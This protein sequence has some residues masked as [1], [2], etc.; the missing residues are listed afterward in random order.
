[1][2]VFISTLLVTLPMLAS[3]SGCAVDPR[4]LGPT[5]DGSIGFHLITTDG[6]RLDSVNY[7]LNTQAGDDV[8]DATLDVSSNGSAITLGIGRLPPGDYS[9]AFVAIGMHAGAPAPCSSEPILF[10]LTTGQAL[11]LPPIALTCLVQNSANQTWSVSPGADIEVE[12]LTVGSAAAAFTYT[13]RDVKGY[14]NPAGACVYPP[15]VLGLT[16]TDSDMAFQ[17]ATNNDGT[18]ALSGGKD[19]AT[20]TCAS[21]G[22]KTLTLLATLGSGT[23]SKTIGVSCDGTSCVPG[24]PICGNAKLDPGEECDE[25]SARCVDCTIHPTCGD[26]IV[27]APE[28][29]DA[30]SLPTATCDV[31][32][33]RVAAQ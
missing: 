17:W 9:L 11:A 1:V 16:S 7:D 24:G 19:Q 25:S 33:R 23:A 6:V 30:R 32:C 14:M 2:R 3:G 21:T 29:C 20:Y 31:N 8:L 28:Q 15:I 10:H 5:G 13:P 4:E 22:E 27:D 12:T 18:F 26:G